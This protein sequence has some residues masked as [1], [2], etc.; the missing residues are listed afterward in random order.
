MHK[1]G[2]PWVA[3]KPENLR[4]RFSGFSTPNKVNFENLRLIGVGVNTVLQVEGIDE[5]HT[6][7]PCR[8]RPRLSVRLSRV[9]AQRQPT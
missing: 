6:N 1:P 8:P 5:K 4:R 3:R 9:A 7:T 2:Q